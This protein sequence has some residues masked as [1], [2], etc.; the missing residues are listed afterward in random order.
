MEESEPSAKRLP[1]IEVKEQDDL[2]TQPGHSSVV[3]ID[4]LGYLLSGCLQH[5]L[6][7]GVPGCL[8]VLR[9]LD[10]GCCP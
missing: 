1:D 8:L 10:K 3:V 4:L 6:L 7:A 9:E 2:V 5:S